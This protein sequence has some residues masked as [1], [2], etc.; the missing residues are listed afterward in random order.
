MGWHHNWCCVI[1]LLW[2]FPKSWNPYNVKSFLTDISV[3]VAQ[4]QK[5]QKNKVH[6][7]SNFAS[8]RTFPTQSTGPQPIQLVPKHRFLQ[9]SRYRS[10]KSENFKKQ[11]AFF[12]ILLL[13][14]PSSPSQLVPN[15]FNRSPN[16]VS[17]R[18]LGIGCSNKKIK[19]KTKCIFSSSNLA[20]GGP[21]PPSQLVP[22]N[23]LCS[24]S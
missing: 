23:L 19:K 7:I 5:N 10:L 17:Y 2:R 21:Y 16:T 18:Y 24:P 15:P 11:G 3:S 20:L 4:I 6:F 8:G 9:I 1:Y 22:N 14:G 12:L 13:G